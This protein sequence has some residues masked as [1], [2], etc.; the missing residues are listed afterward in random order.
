M[1]RITAS[2]LLLTLFS[3]PC[4]RPIS[5]AD[6]QEPQL[7]S[8]TMRQFGKVSRAVRDLDG[9]LKAIQFERSAILGVN[10]FGVSVGGIDAIRDLE[11]D[12][13]VDPET[14][15]GLLAGF[16]IPEV[17]EHLN[18]VKSL[19]GSGNVQLQIGAAD[20]RLRYKGSVVRLYSPKRLAEL[21]DRRESFRI[22]NE[23]ARREAISRYVATRRRDLGD[24]DQNTE[25]SEVVE[26][27]KRFEDI[28]PLLNDLV[29][30]LESEN[31]ARSIIEGTSQ[32]FFGLSIAGINA[33]ANLI[34]GSAVDPETL[35]AIYARRVSGDYAS[36]IEVRNGRIT[37]N[38][39]EIRMY[40][41]DNLIDCFKLREK[42]LIK[43]GG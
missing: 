41:V 22:T 2:L 32:H 27:G 17:A 16:A 1:R 33:E 15:A 24:L 5:A 19:D 6:I 25:R 38:G 20:G 11:E 42:L 31:S 13:G 3:F 43:T 4:T 23:R 40:S 34:D 12:R 30:S 35:G 37:Y 29:T 18:M 26:L 10:Y 8:E 14:M 39:S 7:S 28:E 36:T 21:F 9:F